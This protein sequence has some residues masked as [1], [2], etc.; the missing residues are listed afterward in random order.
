MAL[1]AFKGGLNPKIAVG[2]Y[3]V[4]IYFACELVTLS[5]LYSQDRGIQML[6]KHD[7]FEITLK[8]FLLPAQQ[9]QAH[10]ITRGVV[11]LWSNKSHRSFLGYKTSE[12]KHQILSRYT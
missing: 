7:S 8:I 5:S 6:L 4:D 10:Q 11:D 3:G 9:A 1:L 12:E 2:F